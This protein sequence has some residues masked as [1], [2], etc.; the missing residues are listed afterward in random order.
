MIHSRAGMVCLVLLIAAGVASK[1]VH[2]Q[3]L[4]DYLPQP[5]PVSRESDSRSSFDRALSDLQK[6]APERDKAVPPRTRH[7]PP[8][9]SVPGASIQPPSK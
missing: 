3:T 5:P 6:R 9:E 8:L 4:K 7:D 1:T 2:G